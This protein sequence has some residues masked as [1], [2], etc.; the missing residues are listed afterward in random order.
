MHVLTA[1][2]LAAALLLAVAGASKALDP[3]ST[4][5]AARA[6]R[7]PLTAPVAR[8]F[9][10]AEVVVGLAALLS[11]G[12]V[13]AALVAVSYA[14]FAVFVAVGV[15]RGDLASCGCFSGNDAP[16]S[17]A[18]VVV[19][20]ALAVSA[21]AVALSSGASSL[22][23]AVREDGPWSA[24]LL[25]GLALVEAVLLYLVM[26]RM[27]TARP[28]VSSAQADDLPSGSLPLGVTA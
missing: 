8:L 28:P 14:G 10:V 21:S 27:P 7:L 19:N 24:L 12:P 15:V 2:F 11:G 23:A 13:P 9:G 1:P 18:H 26:T 25:A 17:V 5:R 3:A 4:V 22:T 16:P 6:V 20:M